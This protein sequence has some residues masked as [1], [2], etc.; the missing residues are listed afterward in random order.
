MKSLSPR[1]YFPKF[2]R[3]DN[4]HAN[5]LKSGFIHIREN[6]GRF[7]FFKPKEL[8]GNSVMFQGKMKFCKDVREMS[9]NVTFQH[10]QVRMFGPDVFF[11]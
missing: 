4:A 7:I 6:S 10:D 8:S 1:Q 2:M 11:L 9:R 3:A 5:S